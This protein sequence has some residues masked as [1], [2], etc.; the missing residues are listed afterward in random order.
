[1][2]M[3]PERFW[4]NVE[5]LG[6]D[7]LESCWTWTAPTSHGYG[8]LRVN[9]RRSP[10]HRLAYEALRAD[11]P[12]GLVIDHLCRN[13]PCVNPWHLEP[14]TQG[15]NVLRG[16]MIQRGSE[17]GRSRTHCTN[18]HEF[19]PTNTYIRPGTGG[20]RTCRTC[21]RQKVSEYRERQRAQS[22]A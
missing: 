17:A 4:D 15:V 9:G 21:N 5:Q 20:H 2:N 12:P 8:Y 1:M 7:N 18:G 3:L 13:P 22:V 14:V 10:A 19:T 16:V 6:P 11:I